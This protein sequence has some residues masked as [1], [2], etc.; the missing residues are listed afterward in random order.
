MTD[1]AAWDFDNSLKELKRRFGDRVVAGRP[2]S[3]LNT[4][5]TGGAA[6]LFLEIRSPEEL[7]GVVKVAAKFSIPVFMLGGGSNVLVSDDGYD[8]II[9]RNSIMGM[10]R[11]RSRITCGAGEKLQSLV[12]FA[13]EN[14]LSGL[15]FAAGIW[16]TVGGAIFGNA[17]A[18]GG[19]I[20]SLLESA[21]IVNG[22][23][24]ARTEKAE[25]LGFSYRS[26]RLG[27]TGE[28][29]A[30]ATFRLEEGNKATIARRVEEILLMRE[31]KFPVSSNSAGCFFRNVP[32]GGRKY[33]KLSAGKLLE[34][35]GAKNMAFGGAHVF[36]NHA[37]I[38]INDGS[39]KSE[40]IKRLADLLKA[41]VKH[42]FGIE[43]REE[44]IL[45]G[46][47]KEESL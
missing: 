32:D 14:G 24:N 26:S 28:L 10:E 35:V 13:A 1:K 3:D 2:L 36:E 29:L 43:L 16:G 7:S 4:F 15:E 6:R 18:Y 17:G 5:G 22:Q 20:G 9:I 31:G 8:G 40:D 37:N 11:D 39:A 21:L 44:V 30:R 47:F 38:L 19:E 12:D 23:G 33:G 45:L 41:K 46:D 42:K 25:Y 27:K 34:E